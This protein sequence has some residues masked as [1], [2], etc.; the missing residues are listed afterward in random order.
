MG[1][2]FPSKLPLLT[3]DVNSHLIHA[4]LCPPESSTQMASR[5]VQPFLQGN[6]PCYSVG[7]KRPH[8]GIYIHS[9]AKQPNNNNK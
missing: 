5:S 9:T 8:L 6:R 7:N 3:G 4:F 2:P 1:S